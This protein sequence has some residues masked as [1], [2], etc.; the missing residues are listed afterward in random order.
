MDGV[1]LGI[2]ESILS[3]NEAKSSFS[4]NYIYKLKLYDIVQILNFD[5]DNRVKYPTVIFKITFVK[6]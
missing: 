2:L 3:K 4:I 6:L 5:D 1:F